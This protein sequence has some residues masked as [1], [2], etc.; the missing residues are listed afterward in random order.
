MQYKEQENDMKEMQFH[1]HNFS[2]LNYACWK[3][4]IY[5]HQNLI[6]GQLAKQ[7]NT[8]KVEVTEFLGWQMAQFYNYSPY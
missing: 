5:P 1:V 7:S 6:T 2:S 4:S 3:A 8:V